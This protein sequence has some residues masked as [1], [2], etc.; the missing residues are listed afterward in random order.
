MRAVATK[1]RTINEWL[2][3]GRGRVSDYIIISR[4]QQIVTSCQ[5]G[6][7]LSCLPRH[8]PTLAPNGFSDEHIYNQSDDT[9]HSDVDEQVDDDLAQA[10]H[11]RTE[12]MYI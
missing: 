5:H 9:D 11:D 8:L 7:E 2:I 3:Y 1:F 12:C 6:V 4:W 10:T